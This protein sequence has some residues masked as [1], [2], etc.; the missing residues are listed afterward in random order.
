MDDNTKIEKVSDD[1]IKVVETTETLINIADLVSRR[2]ALQSEVQMYS[3]R[4]QGEVDHFDQLI[5]TAQTELDDI[6][7]KLSAAESLGVASAANADVAE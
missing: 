4:K 5:S 3:S 6:D 1:Q 2:A 7:A